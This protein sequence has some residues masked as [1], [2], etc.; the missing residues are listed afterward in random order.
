VT[1]SCS[2][3]ILLNGVNN[4]FVAVAAADDDD[5]NYFGF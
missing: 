3:R 5:E 4:N 2:I 1:V